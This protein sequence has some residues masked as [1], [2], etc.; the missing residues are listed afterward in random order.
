MNRIDV[1]LPDDFDCRAPLGQNY[2]LVLYPEQRAI[3]YHSWVGNPS[4]PMHVWH[5]RALMVWLPLNAVG[6]D[7]VKICRDEDFQLFIDSIFCRY[8]GT[9]WDGSN[10]VGRWSGDSHDIGLQIDSLEQRIS[11]EVRT[12]WSASSW[13]TAVWGREFA[14]EVREKMAKGEGLD[15]IAQEMEDDAANNDACVSAEDILSELESL[16]EQYPVDDGDDEDDE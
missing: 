11:K 12:W 2:A 13:L 15:D 1:N 4:T 3:S 14:N 7:V 6:K 5:G 8:Q 10:N 16:L 9:E